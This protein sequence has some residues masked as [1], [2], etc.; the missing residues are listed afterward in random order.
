MTAPPLS[1]FVAAISGDEDAALAIAAGY[2][3]LLTRRLGAVI[4][5]MDEP[6][7]SDILGLLADVDHLP[8]GALGALTWPPVSSWLLG[9]QP[10][11][12]DAGEL[13]TQMHVGA[14][15]RFGTGPGIASAPSWLRCQGPGESVAGSSGTLGLRPGLELLSQYST[16]TS[17]LVRLCTRVVA[18]QRTARGESTGS[19]STDELIGCTVLVNAHRDA[20]PAW[21]AESLLHEAVHHCQGMFEVARPFIMDPLLVERPDR[22]P[23][24][25]SGSELTA[26]SLIAACFVWY[27]LAIFWARAGD[28]H[29]PALRRA[30]HGFAAGDPASMI[31]GFAGALDPGVP[32]VVTEL[33]GDIRSRYGS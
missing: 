31:G 8:G 7:C 15:T 13:A 3:D 20:Q 25:W 30:V 5:A 16:G 12:V 27:A 14:A 17:G 1:S 19:W 9:R 10:G 23:S 11:Q 32:A 29:E 33:Q 4:S 6:G 22:Y 2:A 26:K 18:F 24:P 21:L 28:A